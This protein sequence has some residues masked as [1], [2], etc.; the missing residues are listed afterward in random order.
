MLGETPRILTLSP[1][2][3]YFHTHTSNP[4]HLTHPLAHT[5]SQVITAI[6][7]VADSCKE[8]FIAFYDHFVPLLKQIIV[9]AVGKEDRFFR[10]RA[11]ECLT[12]IG[13]SGARAV[14][15]FLEGEI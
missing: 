4:T 3:S 1:Y 8:H 7:M 14:C 10:G 9:Q 2:L 11:M 5:H 13:T 15:V 12:L 6:A